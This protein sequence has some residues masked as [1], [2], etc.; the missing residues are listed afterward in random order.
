MSMMRDFT[1]AEKAGMQNM[2]GHEYGRVL[3][4][5]ST[6]L[7]SLMSGQS[8]GRKVVTPPQGEREPQFEKRC[9]ESTFAEKLAYRGDG[10]GVRAGISFE[11]HT[12]RYVFHVLTLTDVKCRNK[13]FDR[14]SCPYTTTVGN[15]FILTDDNRDLTEMCLLRTI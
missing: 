1:Y 12:D 3:S 4:R 6:L 10:I 2:Y 5:K 9:Y 8:D 15:K 14:F 11:G 7:D 13:I